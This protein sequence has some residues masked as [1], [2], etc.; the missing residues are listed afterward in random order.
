MST[1]RWCAKFG[2]PERTWRRWQ[3]RAR[4]GA[5]AK[6]P[7]PAPVRR[8]AEV[9]AAVQ[10]LAAAHPGW[11]HRRVR[12]RLRERGVEVSEASVLRIMRELGERGRRPA[13]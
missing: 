6:G 8:D 13:R 4:A 10:A 2:I 12:A 1:S 9:V 7:W 3:A 5:S 11:G